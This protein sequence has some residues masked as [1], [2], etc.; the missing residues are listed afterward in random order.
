MF[1]SQFSKTN[2]MKSVHKKTPNY[3]KKKKFENISL[4]FFC[5]KTTEIVLLAKSKL[6]SIEVLTFEALV[7]SNISHDEFVLISNLLTEFYNMKEKIEN[8]NYK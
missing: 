2:Q 6:N 1:Q 3:L 8:S 5:F 4:T 7:S